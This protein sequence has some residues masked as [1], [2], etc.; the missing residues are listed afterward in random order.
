[1][2]MRCLMNLSSG[3]RA[4]PA[5]GLQWDCGVAA[6]G[7]VGRVGGASLKTAVGD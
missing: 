1:M 4:Q 2:K 3:I 5:K 7:L 6:I